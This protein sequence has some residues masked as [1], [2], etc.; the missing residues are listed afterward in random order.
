MTRDEA[1]QLAKREMPERV[2]ALRA[3]SYVELLQLAIATAAFFVAGAITIGCDR[4]VASDQTVLVKAGVEPFI[5]P[6]RASNARV[7]LQGDGTIHY[8]L[9]EPYPA[10]HAVSDVQKAL[11][12]AG[13]IALPHDL[14]NPGLPSSN[15][16]GWRNFVD[17]TSSPKVRVYEWLGY[18]RNGAGDMIM[19]ALR[20]RAQDAG[21][22]SLPVADATG[23]VEL[24]TAGALARARVTVPR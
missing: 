22:G 18:W 17:G 6:T 1:W 12:A 2:A 11:E 3:R 16:V 15:N 20:Y 5:L 14:W 13:W 8:D 24:F 10:Q 21:T 4:S 19:H 9:R 7:I 23:T